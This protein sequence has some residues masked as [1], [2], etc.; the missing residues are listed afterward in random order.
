[1]LLVST[2]VVAHAFATSVSLYAEASG[3]GGGP[4]ALAQGLDP[5]EGIVVPTLGAYD[6]VAM[7]L[8]PFVVIRAFSIERTTGAQTLVM[9]L[10]VSF[11]FTLATRALVLLGVWIVA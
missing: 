8:L 10:P 11:P 1:M 6:L 7:L 5:R 4:A 3:A 2:A 9:Q